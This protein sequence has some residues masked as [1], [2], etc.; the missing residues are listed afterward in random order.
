MAVRRPMST[1]N[2]QAEPA[3]K[4]ARTTSIKMAAAPKRAV[5]KAGPKRTAAKPPRSSAT[6]DGRKAAAMLTELR[7]EGAA[8]SARVGR[9]LQ[10]FS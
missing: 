10:R 8:L 9:L 1:T 6:T 2:T 4:A 3:S 7:T 5:A